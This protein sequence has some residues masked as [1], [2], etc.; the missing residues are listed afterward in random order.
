MSYSFL[1]A[2]RRLYYVR[3][4]A[5][6]DDSQIWSCSLYDRESCHAVASKVNAFYLDVFSVGRSPNPCATNNGGCSHICVLIP[7]AP[8]R[9]WIERLLYVATTSGLI[10]ISLDTVHHTPM[11]FSNAAPEIRDT[12]IVH[13]DF[14]PVD[15][16]L[17]L[18]DG[19]MG[20]IRKCN[21]DGTE[22]EIFIEDSVNLVSE[23]LA[24]DWLNRNLYW[25]DSN[26]AQI[27]MQSLSGKGRQIVISH[28]LKQPRGLAVDADGGYIYF[29]DWHESTSR[30]EKAWLDGSHRQ[31][32]VSLEKDAWP[33]GI[34]VDS[35][36]KRLYWAEGSRSLIKSAALNGNL[37]VQIFSESVNHP[38]S[39]SIL[40]NTLYC[41][42]LYGRK[43]SAFRVPQQNETFPSER[44]SVVSDAVIFGQ[45]GIRAVSLNQIPEGSSPCQTNNGGCSHICVKL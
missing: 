14:D 34:A 37:D 12:K 36:Q 40:G 26:V 1:K 22:M 41:N 2:N 42:S 18:I 9:S 17:F 39:L 33:N 32:V 31:V 45:M 23:A 11:P 19:D 3:T 43:I 20:V 6:P 35:R 15:R 28:G 29:S 5:S 16:K 4:R 27:K 13:V 24:V 10:Y 38:Y 7:G 44:L 21:P 25:L 30:I 8:W